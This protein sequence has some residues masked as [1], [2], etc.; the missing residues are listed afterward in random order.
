MGKILNRINVQNLVFDKNSYFLARPTF[1]THPTTGALAGYDLTSSKMIL[2]VNNL[3]TFEYDLKANKVD[4]EDYLL[5][6]TDFFED[7]IE[8]DKDNNVYSFNEISDVIR[9]NGEDLLTGITLW[10]YTDKLL[11]DATEMLG[12]LTILGGGIY[13]ETVTISWNSPNYQNNSYV[14]EHKVLNYTFLSG[15]WWL[16]L[17]VPQG[18]LINGGFLTCNVLSFT[19]LCAFSIERTFVYQN[20]SSFE[21]N[22]LSKS[23]NKINNSDMFFLTNY[24][25]KIVPYINQY[26]LVEQSGAMR[27]IP[28][29][30]T[31]Q[32]YESDTGNNTIFAT[33]SFTNNINS[34]NNNTL[35]STITSSQSYVS[36]DKTSN[37]YITSATFSFGLSSNINPTEKKINIYNIKQ[38]NICDWKKWINIKYINPYGIWD[39]MTLVGTERAELNVQKNIKNQLNYEQGIQIENIDIGLFGE[40]KNNEIKKTITFDSDHLDY[41]QYTQFGEVLESKY[42]KIYTSDDEINYDNGYTAP[43]I[44][45][46][47]S[48]GLTG[49]NVPE[50]IFGEYYFNAGYTITIA[51]IWG[52]YTHTI[53]TD[54]I[55]GPQYGDAVDALIDEI[56]LS[57]P[58]FTL[59][60]VSGAGTTSGKSD[61]LLFTSN[62]LSPTYNILSYTNSSSIDID[63]ASGIFDLPIDAQVDINTFITNDDPYKNI[64]IEDS[65]FDIS[66]SDNN[67]LFKINFKYSYPKV[68]RN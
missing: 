14:G 6:L 59:T 67:D 45:I 11:I 66:Y 8:V 2:T 7:Y 53:G 54:T 15:Q 41:D 24:P 47:F 32:Q 57:F 35:L 60:S 50:N 19:R 38:Q 49:S 16:I 13:P 5:K 43:S 40:I 42:T 56:S 51:G 39:S 18:E 12:M 44:K 61:A 37:A 22:S 10:Q 9:T 58:N 64:I 3:A 28:T 46:D 1:F 52:T 62:I 17:D 27:F 33:G 23:A 31:L 21:N 55:S 4:G 30:K 68:L 25:N 36:A 29:L 48:L 26:H 34:Y 63:H 20:N 65:N